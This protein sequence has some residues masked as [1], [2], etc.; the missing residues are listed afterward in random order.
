MVVHKQATYVQK[1]R[2]RIIKEQHNRGDIDSFVN[3]E[4]RVHA[5]AHITSDVQDVMGWVSV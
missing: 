1:R 5:R 2:T 3:C 4:G